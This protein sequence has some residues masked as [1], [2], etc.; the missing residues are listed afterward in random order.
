MSDKYTDS[1]LSLIEH[2]SHKTSWIYYIQ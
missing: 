2:K 1:C